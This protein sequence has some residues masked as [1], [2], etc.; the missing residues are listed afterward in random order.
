MR[1]MG[2]VVV[3]VALM[4]FVGSRSAAAASDVDVL[5]IDPY[6][7]SGVSY[8]RYP[9]YG[10]PIAEDTLTVFT[11]D[12]VRSSYDQ[13]LPGAGDSYLST[14]VNGYVTPLTY[15]DITTASTVTM[16]WRYSGLGYLDTV[17]ISV[18]SWADDIGLPVAGITA[19][20]YRVVDGVRVLLDE[21]PLPDAYNTIN[22]RGLFFGADYL[23]YSSMTIDVLVTM[24]DAYAKII[25]PRVRV[26][27]ATV[28]GSGFVATPTATALPVGYDPDNDN[29][30]LFNDSVNDGV[31]LASPLPYVES[32]AAAMDAV[33]PYD[34]QIAESDVTDYDITALHG[35]M[36]DD[37]GLGLQILNNIFLDP[38]YTRISWIF[39]RGDGRVSTLTN[40]GLR[41]FT[42]DLT[43]KEVKFSGTYICPPSPVPS[44]WG[45]PS[46][47]YVSMCQTT[48]PSVVSGH[49]S[50]YPNDPFNFQKY[51]VG[52]ACPK[53]LV[54]GRPIVCAPALSY[55]SNMTRDNRPS[56][57]TR[58]VGKQWWMQ[59]KDVW[60]GQPY[61][62]NFRSTA[63]AVSRDLTPTATQKLVVTAVKTFTPVAT[64]TQVA[65]IAATRT[66]QARYKQTQTK[67]ALDIIAT[68]RAAQT[69]VALTAT[70]QKNATATAQRTATIAYA[71]T[72]TALKSGYLT[73]V[74]VAKT[75]AAA[76]VTR[77]VKVNDYSALAAVD[78][79]TGMNAASAV[80]GS[81]GP[82]AALQ[83][84][85]GSFTS[86][87]DG[88]RSSPCV[89][90][91]PVFNFGTGMY[92]DLSQIHVW[93]GDGLCIVYTWLKQNESRPVF[94]FIRVIFGIVLTLGLIRIFISWLTRG[95]RA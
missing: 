89:G 22:A 30:V 9:A 47:N 41:F 79:N 91:P 28:V 73:A 35:K 2:V 38:R 85:V 18:I 80:A 52:I 50:K 78:T 67:I 92:F 42:Y 6:V 21:L 95:Q 40:V 93:I 7:T 77:Q 83:T 16:G 71:A 61:V 19:R 66:A 56:Q 69:K 84:I 44:T 14:S 55:Q 60:P 70:A 64:V 39:G 17:N 82:V 49:N 54:N 88:L 65:N 48:L 90:I 59:F 62:W 63:T 26:C 33:R 37:Y 58:T 72:A 10:L 12:N 1:Y 24:P 86:F 32:S 36:W 4:V 51:A 5:T 11:I 74:V 46:I 25:Y 15:D 13:C 43:T 31:Y 81:L 34:A 27:D 20:V 23:Q 68:S 3:V 57:D 53:V 76:T 87:Y 75:S 29:L 8:T 45:L 94:V